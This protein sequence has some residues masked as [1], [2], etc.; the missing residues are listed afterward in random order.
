MR[1]KYSLAIFYRLDRFRYLGSF[2]SHSLQKGM[3]KKRKL[4]F[5]SNEVYLRWA[6]NRKKEWT[7]RPYQSN[8][9]K[10][11][12]TCPWV[13]FTMDL[14]SLGGIT[15]GLL[16]ENNFWNVTMLFRRWSAWR[17]QPPTIK[18]IDYNILFLFTLRQRLHIKSYTN[19]QNCWCALNEVSRLSAAYIFS[20][21]RG[22][23]F[24]RCWSVR[25]R[26]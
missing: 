23:S 5:F 22:V 8:Q 21:W 9:E 19:R 17:G 14:A 20:Q 10:K 11:G 12:S 2:P 18:A 16:I 26:V 4:R 13:Y 25:L 1:Q 6:K 3:E 15:E 24:S 7:G